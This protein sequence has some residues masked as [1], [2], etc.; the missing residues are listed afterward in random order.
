LKIAVI[1]TGFPRT[2]SESFFSLEK[3]LLRKYDVDLFLATWNKDE[4]NLYIK[5]DYTKY[6]Q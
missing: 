5:E 1:L 6:Y 4:N 2:Y 3:N